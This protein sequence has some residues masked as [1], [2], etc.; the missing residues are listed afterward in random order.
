MT[1]LGVSPPQLTAQVVQAVTPHMGVETWADF[2]SRL[3]S[4]QVKRRDV[5]QSTGQL[6]GLTLQ[7]S[8]HLTRLCNCR[9][10]RCALAALRRPSSHQHLTVV[11]SCYLSSTQ[12]AGGSY[13]PAPTLPNQQ[14]APRAS[15]ESGPQRC[16]RHMYVCT[17]GANRTA[18]WPLHAF[19]QH[20][21]SLHLADLPADAQ[22]FVR[23]QPPLA[24][25][26]RL[27]L[28]A[29]GAAGNSRKAGPRSSRQAKPAVLN[30]LF[31]QRSG[32]RMLLNVASLLEPQGLSCTFVVRSELSSHLRTP[33]CLVRSLKMD[34]SMYTNVSEPGP[35]RS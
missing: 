3:P 17:Q 21:V 28:A 2:S 20:L 18:T 27:R 29:E 30:V 7:N 35:G 26:R 10:C 14:G 16:F 5:L 32:D 6:R 11:P 25:Q 19:G 15:W 31:H 12:V 4:Q 1:S 9:W 34:Y 13:L 23:T 24:L 8:Q 33:T 22:A